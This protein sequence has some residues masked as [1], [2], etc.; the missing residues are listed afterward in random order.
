[1]DPEEIASNKSQKVFGLTEAPDVLSTTME[2]EADEAAWKIYND[3]ANTVDTELIRDWKSTLETLLIFGAL[4]TAVLTA[5]IIESIKLLQEDTGETTRDILLTV[6][7]QLANTSTPAF[8]HDEF[9]QETWAVRVNYYFFTSISCSLVAA[10]GAVLAL[11][12]IGSYDFGLIKSSVKSRAIQRQLRYNGIEKWR[13]AQLISA[14]PLLIYISVFLFFVG[15]ADWL[16]HIHRRVAGIVISGLT[17][18]G[19]LYIITHAICIFD[20][21]APFRTPASRSIPYIIRKFHRWLFDAACHFNK[22]LRGERRKKPQRPQDHDKTL[23]L[24]WFMKDIAK[25]V[26]GLSLNLQSLLFALHATVMHPSEAKPFKDREREVLNSTPALERDGILWLAKTIDILPSSRPHFVALLKE[27]VLIS[28]DELMDSRMDVAPW[29]EIF[30]NVFQKFYEKEMTT[31]KP[32]SNEELAELET[33]FEAAAFIGTFEFTETSVASFSRLCRRIIQ[34]EWGKISIFAGLAMWKCLHYG[35]IFTDDSL[36]LNLSNSW[37][38]MVLYRIYHPKKMLNKRQ[39]LLVNFLG[40]LATSECYKGSQF[41]LE[42]RTILILLQ[43]VTCIQGCDLYPGTEWD[44]YIQ[45]VSHLPSPDDSDY[46]ILRIC[47]RVILFQFLSHAPGLPDIRDKVFSS[48]IQVDYKSE[49]FSDARPLMLTLLQNMIKEDEG[50][51]TSP[52]MTLL[53][54]VVSWPDQPSTVSPAMQWIDTLKACDEILRQR[55]N[56]G[57]SLEL[58]VSTFLLAVKPTEYQ[59]DPPEETIECSLENPVI[60]IFASLILPVCYSLA[61]LKSVEISPEMCTNPSV[62]HLLK[63]WCTNYVHP[64]Q[65]DIEAECMVLMASA[66]VQDANYMT[67]YIHRQSDQAA[68]WKVL[69]TK[70]LKRLFSNPMGAYILK[71]VQ[72]TSLFPNCFFENDGI[73]WAVIRLNKLPTDGRPREDIEGLV[74]NCIKQSTS[75][76]TLHTGLHLIAAYINATA[77]L[78]AVRPSYSQLN[79]IL[80][81]ILDSPVENFNYSGY[82][83]FMVSFLKDGVE[84]ELKAEIRD[85]IAACNP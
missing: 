82:S 59:V 80:Q 42:Y 4:F 43:I 26:H 51:L 63:A 73:V 65:G 67:D 15:L 24:Q 50:S 57:F 25:K 8:E 49:I 74:L 9:T 35:D 72:G 69:L 83:P 64:S 11:Q 60:L 27:T 18:A 6:S 20:I 68:Y 76:S 16:W 44:R 39:H 1:M 53:G 38:H 79:N 56:S 36:I 77:S 30:Q 52:A 13:L 7:R 10:L 22:W 17:I 31:P 2:R 66:E 3:H 81:N 32:Y 85:L 61:P 75:R 78:E 45:A 40:P 71:Q 47:H 23:D 33:L 21:C 48:L 5:F 70:Y 41:L 84:V 62:P 55:N 58:L 19:L 29:S 28:T 14:L 54:V 34:R 37:V 46:D 12:W